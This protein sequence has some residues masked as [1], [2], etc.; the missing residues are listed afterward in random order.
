MAW[1]LVFWF[2]LPY[3]ERL[4]FYNSFYSTLHFLLL[5]LL[6]HKIILELFPS[7]TQAQRSSMLSLCHTNSCNLAARVFFF[8]Q[9]HLFS[10][11][12]FTQFSKLEYSKLEE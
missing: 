7:L 6:L 9:V 1:Y 11:L 5:T 12:A 10:V 4:F 2:Y 3:L 8:F